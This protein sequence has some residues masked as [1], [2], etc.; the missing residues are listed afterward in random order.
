MGCSQLRLVRNHCRL[1]ERFFDASTPAWWTSLANDQEISELGLSGTNSSFIN[2]DQN[3]IELG[4]SIRTTRILKIP[5]GTDQ[6][7]F[8]QSEHL[9][10]NSFQRPLDSHN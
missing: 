4:F 9:I 6:S 3:L 7:D 1:S 10:I 8:V 2:S 5:D